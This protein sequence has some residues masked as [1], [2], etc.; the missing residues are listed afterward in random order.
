MAAYTIALPK[1]RV[2]PLSVEEQ[3]TTGCNVRWRI[4][5][6][7]IAYATAT[8]TDDVLTFTLGSTPSNWIVNRALGNVTTAFAGSTGT[9]TLGVGTTSSTVA[10]ISAQDIKTAGP[11]EMV[12]TVPIGTNAQGTSALSIVATATQ[13][14]GGSFST[15]T[16]GQVDIY[17]NV[18]NLNDTYAK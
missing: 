3:A 10:F 11:L 9:A 18:V 5:A 17:L 13:N 8:A 14:T 16:A 4:L 1:A 12:S 7:D 15:V 6:S 2:S